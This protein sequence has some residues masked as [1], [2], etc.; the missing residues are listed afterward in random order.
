MVYKYQPGKSKGDVWCLLQLEM[1]L[2]DRSVLSRDRSL[3]PRSDLQLLGKIKVVSFLE[4]FK[5]LSKISLYSLGIQ[6]L[7]YR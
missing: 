4:L 6:E 1:E 3:N 7:R 2:S 5:E